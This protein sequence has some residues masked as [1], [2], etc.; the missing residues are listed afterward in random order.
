MKTRGFEII[1]LEQWLNDFCAEGNS[2]QFATEIY[3]TLSLPIKSTSNAAGCDL[4][5]PISFE[6][7][8]NEEIKIPTGLKAYMQENEMLNIYPRSGQGFKFYIRLANTVGIGD[9]DYYA[10]EGNEGHYWVKLRNEGNKTFKIKKGERFAQVIFVPCLPPD[11]NTYVDEQKK[12]KG[13][14]GHTGK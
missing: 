11:E 14:L 1:S 2:K 13:G 4:V 10:N 6:L 3:N 7:N 9:D 5:S 8:P 12:R